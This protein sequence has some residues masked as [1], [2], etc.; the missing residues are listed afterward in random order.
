MLEARGLGLMSWR[1]TSSYPSEGRAH[2]GLCARG[3][4]LCAA[5]LSQVHG[6]PCCP[7]PREP[8]QPGAS[9]ARVYSRRPGSSGAVLAEEFWTK[10]MQILFQLAFRA[11]GVRLSGS[12][13]GFRFLGNQVWD[14]QTASP[15]R[16]S[17][18]LYPLLLQPCPPGPVTQDTEGRTCSRQGPV[19]EPGPPMPPRL[20]I[21]RLPVGRRPP[22]PALPVPAEPLTL[23]WPGGM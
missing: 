2:H 17:R 13:S 14:R 10:S 18:A 23:A 5:W 15:E 20:D 11:T 1:L 9:R 3:S 6:D 7:G 4:G 22:G 19:G 12:L 16:L 8:G 21:W